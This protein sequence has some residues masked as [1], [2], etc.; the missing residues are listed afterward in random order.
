MIPQSIEE[1][2]IRYKLQKKISKKD[3][4]P[5]V[6]RCYQQF[7]L[8]IILQLNCESYSMQNKIKPNSTSL[9]INAVIKK[10]KPTEKNMKDKILYL[11]ILNFPT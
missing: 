8:R 2:V 5:K 6:R 3:K 7:F 10:N 1:K 11:F 9:F 4:K